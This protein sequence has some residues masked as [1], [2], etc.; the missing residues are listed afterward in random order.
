VSGGPDL[1]REAL[2][3]PCTSLGRL[4]LS[5]LG[6]GSG[7]ELIKQ[8]SGGERDLL[9]STIEGLCVGLRWLRRAA[10]LAD[11]LKRSVPYLALGGRGFVIVE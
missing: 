9:D 8:A 11:I 2:L 7:H 1:R 4:E 3:G 10:D 5:I 6:R